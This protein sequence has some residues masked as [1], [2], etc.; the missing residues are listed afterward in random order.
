MLKKE[1]ILPIF[2]SGFPCPFRCSYCNAK[3]SSGVTETLGSD[4][5]E[6][7][8]DNWIADI[9]SKSTRQVALYGNDI[10]SLGFEVYGPIFDTLRRFY[11]SRKIDSIRISVRPDTLDQLKNLHSFGVKTVE[12]GVP[13]MREAVLERIHRG[14]GVD[15]V[16]QAVKSLK[17]AGMQIGIQTM[18]GLPGAD[19]DE[20]IFTAHAI[21]KLSP[22]FVRIHPVLVLK[23]TTLCDDYLSQSYDP[24]S[25]DQ[26]ISRS[27]EAV[28]IYT[29]HKIAVARIGFFIPESLVN[30]ILVSGPYHPCLGTIVRS[31]IKY[32][33]L[34]E[35]LKH[36]PNEKS[37]CVSRYELSAAI[38]FKKNNL[39][40]LQ[41]EFSKDLRILCADN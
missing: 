19:T 6:M 27:V 24:L 9:E 31:E 5:I 4:D 7:I 11:T 8:V 10:P 21:A 34:K 29:E 13:S 3:A 41:R 20:H 38:G 35:Y 33:E 12:L 23:N 40:R 25:L 28:K 1:K 17:I 16:R 39:L 2:L 18:I 36:H 37:I 22:D 14:H 30:S 26:A 32:L 15:C